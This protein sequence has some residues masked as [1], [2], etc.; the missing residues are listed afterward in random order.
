MCSTCTASTAHPCDVAVHLVAVTRAE[1]VCVVPG[2]DGGVHVPH[3]SD[4]ASSDQQMTTLGFNLGVQVERALVS[5]RF[6]NHPFF[7]NET[8]LVLFK[9]GSSL[10]RPHHATPG[11]GA[12]RSRRCGASA[13]STRST[14]LV[15]SA[16]RPAERS[17]LKGAP[18]AAA[19]IDAAPAL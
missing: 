8:G 19:R 5:S 9:S 11:G 10:H 18:A 6:S 15:S 13:K 16:R 4:K 3:G 12:R 17:R 7:S 1:Q 2:G 14:R